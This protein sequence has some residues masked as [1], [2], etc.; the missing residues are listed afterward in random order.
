M[1]YIVEQE[2][3]TLRNHIVRHQGVG[4][5]TDNCQIWAHHLDAYEKILMLMKQASR[6][7]GPVESSSA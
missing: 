6:E 7:V 1:I 2:I 4:C 5:Y 3:A